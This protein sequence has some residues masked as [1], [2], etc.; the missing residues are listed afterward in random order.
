MSFIVGCLKYFLCHWFSEI[1]R[2]CLVVLPFVFILLWLHWPCWLYVC[3]LGP[4]LKTF[5]PLF[6]SDFS[7]PLCPLCG[8]HFICGGPVAFLI[9]SHWG[10]LCSILVMFIV[11]MSHI[12][13]FFICGVW[14][15]TNH[16]LC[17]FFLLHLDHVFFISF[18][19]FFYL[20]ICLSVLCLPLTL[21]EHSC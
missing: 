4:H 20:F 12:H 21:L 17:I 11:T 5:L 18:I 10:C 19:C 2:M 6:L 15:A 1:G 9:L 16:I 14:S 8:V 3:V 7:S 13:C